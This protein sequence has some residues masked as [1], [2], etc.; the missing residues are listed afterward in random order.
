[1][2]DTAKGGPD[3]LAAVLT[4]FGIKRARECPPPRFHELYAR[5]AGILEA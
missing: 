2:Q 3:R 5:L 1:V 4:E